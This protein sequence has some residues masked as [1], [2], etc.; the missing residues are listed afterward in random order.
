VFLSRLPSI[1]HLTLNDFC[2][3]DTISLV[4]K[5]CTALQYLRISLGP[6]SF[7]EQQLSDEGF[8]DLIEEQQLHG[9]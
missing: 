3:D 2:D 5:V 8:S 4:G 6:E 1:T 7:S 9:R